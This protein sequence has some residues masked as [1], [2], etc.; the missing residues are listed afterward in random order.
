MEECDSAPTVQQDTSNN[1]VILQFVKYPQYQKCA[2]RY[3]TFQS[4]PKYHL[5]SGEDLAKAGF[6]YSGKGDIVFCF[7][8]GIRLKDWEPCDKVWNE[9][10]KHSTSCLYLEMCRLREKDKDSPFSR[11]TGLF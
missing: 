2:N 8:C 6:V 5:P 10:T 3:I 9:H 1:G 4:W 7:C 11:Q